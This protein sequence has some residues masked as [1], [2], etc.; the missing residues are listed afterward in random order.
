MQ[1]PR[2]LRGKA[3]RHQFRFNASSW[4]QLWDQDTSKSAG[5]RKF[6]YKGLVCCVNPFHDAVVSSHEMAHFVPCRQNSR[7]ANK[8]NQHYIALLPKFQAR[9]RGI[10][11][12]G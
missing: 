2:L 1:F 3:N 4:R 6:K 11:G 9:A 5:K 10:F 12:R 7:P 8:N